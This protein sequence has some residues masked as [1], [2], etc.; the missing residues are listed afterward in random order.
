MDDRPNVIDVAVGLLHAPEGARAESVLTWNL[1]AQMMSEK[2]FGDTWRG[3]LVK[4][5]KA[6]S[7]KWRTRN[8]YEKTWF[9]ANIEGAQDNS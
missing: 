6:G 2:E 8:G 3:N 7:E 4:S 1:G 9:R 5:V